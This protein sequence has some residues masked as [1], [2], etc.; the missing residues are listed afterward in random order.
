M[1]SVSSLSRELIFF[2]KAV[3]FCYGVFVTFLYHVNFP[4]LFLKCF[5]GEKRISEIYTPGALDQGLLS[6]GSFHQA[7]H[8]VTKKGKIKSK[9]P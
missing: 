3:A 1:H 7:A 6:L 4:L 2:K 5:R 8:R 9:A